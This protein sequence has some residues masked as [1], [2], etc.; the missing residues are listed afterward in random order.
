MK[1]VFNK[2]GEYVVRFAADAK[3]QIHEWLGENCPYEFAV[4]FAKE[5]DCPVFGKALDFPSEVV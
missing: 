4:K 5:V 1:K 3:N 2:D